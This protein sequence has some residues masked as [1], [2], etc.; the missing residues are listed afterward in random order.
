MEDKFQGE[1]KISRKTK[2]RFKS[3]STYIGSQ[4]EIEH[5]GFTI[6]AMER[7]HISYLQLKDQENLLGF[8]LDPRIYSLKCW[9]KEIQKHKGSTKLY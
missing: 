1:S 4:G 7:N 3:K 8:L 2:S 6:R 5:V 9:I